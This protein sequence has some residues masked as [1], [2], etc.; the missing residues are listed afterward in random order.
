MI[1]LLV[2]VK[3]NSMQIRCKQSNLAQKDNNCT[4]LNGLSAY[5]CICVSFGPITNYLGNFS[6]LQSN[7][8]LV[9]SRSITVCVFVCDR[10]GLLIRE[11]AI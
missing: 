8:P 5:K 4:T 6:R 11:R 2:I 9:N 1:S 3:S 7:F 10:D